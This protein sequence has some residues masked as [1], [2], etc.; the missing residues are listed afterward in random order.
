M[1]IHYPALK[2]EKAH[3]KIPAHRGIDCNGVIAIIPNWAN[4]QCKYSSES[5]LPFSKVIAE[6]KRV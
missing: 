6:R 3:K 5:I 1:N 4:S 2:K